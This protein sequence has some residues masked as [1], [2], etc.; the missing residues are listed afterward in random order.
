[1]LGGNNCLSLNAKTE[2]IKKLVQ[3][4]FKL[5]PLGKRKK[6]IKEGESQQ[7]AT[8]LWADLPQMSLI[9]QIQSAAVGSAK[10]VYWQMGF[11]KEAILNRLL[12]IH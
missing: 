2:K 4:I 1:M 7:Y 10:L 6:F 9:I 12:P 3:R 8:V 5:F 11:M